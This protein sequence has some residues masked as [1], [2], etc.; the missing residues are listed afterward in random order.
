MFPITCSS[1]KCFE[2]DM[3]GGE[4]LHSLFH[5]KSGFGITE[6]SYP[7]CQI[8]NTGCVGAVHSTL[9]ATSSVIFGAA[10][11]GNAILLGSDVCTTRFLVQ[12]GIGAHAAVAGTWLGALWTG[13]NSELTRM[14]MGHKL[15]NTTSALGHVYTSF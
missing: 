8:D 1:M 13:W 10:P 11:S 14:T 4:Y 5:G 6:V 2:N 3:V 7:T 9:D 15:E 12:S